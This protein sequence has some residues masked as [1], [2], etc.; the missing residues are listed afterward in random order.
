MSVRIK[1][2]FLAGLLAA[3]LFLNAY[4]LWAEGSGALENFSG[5]ER[6]REAVWRLA[7]FVPGEPGHRVLVVDGVRGLPPVT[8][9]LSFSEALDPWPESITLSFEAEA[10]PPPLRLTLNDRR[11]FGGPNILLENLPAKSA[12][13]REAADPPRLFLDILQRLNSRLGAKRSKLGRLE[14]RENAP[15][16]EMARASL[17]YGAR[18]GPADLFLL[19]VDSSRYSF[20]PYH[21]SEFPGEQPADLGAWGE[22]LKEAPAL[23]NGGQYYPDRSYMGRLSRGGQIFS[24]KDHP[25]WKAFLAAAPGPGAPAGAPQATIID[26]Q[27]TG[28]TLQPEHYGN[29][30]Q[31]FMILDAE[32][33][34]RVRDSHNLA[35]RAA[36]GED[37][38]GRMV[39]IMTPAAVS[40]Y[41]LALVLQSPDLKL[42]RVM[43]LDG[44]FE[45]QLLLRQNGT[46]FLSGGQFSISEQRA[47]YLP[48]YRPSLPVILAVEPLEIQAEANPA[49]EEGTPRPEN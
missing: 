18:I 43:G 36:I 39:L 10:G 46:P 24:A 5:N 40:L 22:R 1:I 27:E 35:A 16:L 19:R 41:D 6:L 25:G 2:G 45:A 49:D 30:M 17:F 20:S 44:G 15:G 12:A 13:Q 3:A 9:H 48:G 42:K 33:R 29:L 23:I 4:A 38:E 26:R 8:I 21:E 37:D 31:S 47:L 34:I 11:P 7:A 32:G 28:R 14:W